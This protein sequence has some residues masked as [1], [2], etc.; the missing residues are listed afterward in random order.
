MGHGR[1]LGFL[2]ASLMQD[3][4]ITHHGVGVDGECWMVDSA[5]P[6]VNAGAP[7]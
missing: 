7:E 5:G 1:Q 6:C 4:E 3:E 2:E